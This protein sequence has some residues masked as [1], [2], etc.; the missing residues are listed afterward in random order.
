MVTVALEPELFSKFDAEKSIPSLLYAFTHPLAYNE[1]PELM[2]L[3]LYKDFDFNTLS[4]I[5]V[6]VAVNLSA[7]PS[8]R[9]FWAD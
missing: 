4:A 2:C 6:P 7:K 5:A 8:L 1:A 3:D 9:M